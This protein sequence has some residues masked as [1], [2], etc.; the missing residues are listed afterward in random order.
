MKVISDKI[1]RFTPKFW[2]KVGQLIPAW[3]YADCKIGLMQNNGKNYHYK[4]EQYKKYKANG[5]RRFT[6]GA[7]KMFSDKEGYSYGKTYFN[8]PK[9]GKSKKTGFTTGGRLSSLKGISIDS[10]NTSFVDMILTGR[11]VKSLKPK[12]S[13]EISVTMAYPPDKAGIVLG[14]KRRGYNIIGLNNQ[15][16][17]KVRQL[18][19]KQLDD[20]QKA[21]LGKK[22]VITIG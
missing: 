16:I 2:L 10:T 18:I 14:N 7:G 12:T 1:V 15:N 17:K 13:D 19:V 20:N 11:T 9:A 5:M 21:M 22:M 8:N 6:K 4:S 3:V